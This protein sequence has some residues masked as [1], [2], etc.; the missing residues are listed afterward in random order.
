[1]IEQTYYQNLH[2]VLEDYHKYKKK[3]KTL[4]FHRKRNYPFFGM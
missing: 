1:M 3:K 4:G 2:E